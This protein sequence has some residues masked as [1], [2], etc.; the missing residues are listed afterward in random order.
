MSSHPIKSNIINKTVVGYES[1]NTFFTYTIRSQTY[2]F[3]IDI[4][5]G[6]FIG[7]FRIFRIGFSNTFINKRIFSILIIIILVYLPCIIG[8]I[9]HDDKNKR[10]F[11]ALGSLCIFS[12]KK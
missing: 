4:R 12:S 2:Y 9:T 7:S 11:L 10:V 1:N 3:D 5:K 8:W 6:I